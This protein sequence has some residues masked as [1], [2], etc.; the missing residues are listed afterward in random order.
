MKRVHS[1]P[2]AK[3]LEPLLKPLG[4]KDALMLFGTVINEPM[5]IRKKLTMSCSTWLSTPLIQTQ[6]NITKGFL[7]PRFCLSQKLCLEGMGSFSPWHAAS[8]RFKTDQHIKPTGIKP[9][10]SWSRWSCMCFPKMEQQEGETYPFQLS[11]QKGR[12]EACL[13]ISQAS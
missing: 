2:W 13:A 4:F 12:H 6:I 8:Y 5:L 3:D 11:N 9:C 7:L 10:L 1:C